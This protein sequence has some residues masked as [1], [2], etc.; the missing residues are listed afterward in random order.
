M[1]TIY[2]SPK[3]FK[4][5]HVKKQLTDAGIAYEE[6]DVQIEENRNKLISLNLLSLPVMMYEDKPYQYHEAQTLIGIVRGR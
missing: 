2:T 5:S 4:C 1:V 6:K 3:C